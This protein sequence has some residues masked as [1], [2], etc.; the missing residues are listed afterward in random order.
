MSANFKKNIFKMK[1]TILWMYNM[2]LV[3]EAGGTERITSLIRNGLL[4]F[5]YNCMTMLVINPNTTV[6]EYEGEKVNDIYAFL[7]SY[8]V[9]VVINQ[10]G[11]TNKVLNIF[12]AKGGSLWQKEGGKI[13][14]CLHFD[15]DSPSFEKLIFKK[16]NKTVKDW[17]L[18]LKCLLLHGY[19]KR[20]KDHQAGI[21]YNE[22]YD[23]SD[24]F[25]C[26]SQFHFPYLRQV[27]K[28]RSYDKMIAINNPLTFDDISDYSIL[29]KKKKQ[30]LV[31]A[32]MDEFYKRISLI[33]K[34]WQCLDELDEWQLVIIGDGPSLND[35]KEFS[36]KNK[37]CNI[38]FL[39][40]QSPELYYKDSSI[41]LMTSD[42][43]G[44]GLTLT[45]SL[46][47]GVVPVVMNS[48]PVFSE[49]II[50]GENG[51]LTT[52]GNVKEF[53]DKVRFLMKN[54]KILREMGKRA[55]VS[56][57]KFEIKETLKQWEKIL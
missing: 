24:V 50:D 16:K 5:G 12:L 25:V 32:R 1:K 47:R 21:L 7:K 43:E 28:R 53:A 38:H 18:L 35:Y 30:I 14:T 51:F 48:C 39:G 45:E 6:V 44:W 37:L 49:I 4:K 31:V 41:Y 29:D 8:A 33:L 57:K 34:G 36:T 19:Y 3:P 9:D 42:K 26:L 56:A 46:Q 55:L 10:D 27:M 23:K 13:I 15:P 20:K 2:P 52:N 54:P 17:I 22:L 11:I 40:R